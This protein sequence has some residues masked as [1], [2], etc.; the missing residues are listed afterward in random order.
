VA[1]VPDATRAQDWEVRRA[2][3][4]ELQNWRLTG[5]VAFQLEREAWSAT[6]HWQQRNGEYVLRVIAPLGRGSFELTGSDSGVMLRTADNRLL[7]ADDAQALLRQNLG[8]ELPV[9]GLFY[10]IR[11]LPEPTQSADTIR[12]DEKGRIHDL[13][14]DGWEISYQ[15]YESASGYELPGKMTLQNDR[16]RLRLTIRDWTVSS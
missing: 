16:L 9:S 14:Q 5:R 7:H 2:R 13:R 15:S 3:L 4:Y 10:W 12:F 1:P 6:L 11:G 8:W